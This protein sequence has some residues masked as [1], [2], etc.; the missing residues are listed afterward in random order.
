MTIFFTRIY[1]KFYEVGYIML[2]Y[3]ISED[4]AL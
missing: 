2:N 1:V 3:L 4:S